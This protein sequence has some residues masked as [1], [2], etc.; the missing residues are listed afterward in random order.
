MLIEERDEAQNFHDYA[1]FPLETGDTAK[2]LAMTASRPRMGVR[3]LNPLAA[4]QA[5]QNLTEYQELRD[6]AR[7]S[8]CAV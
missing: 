2:L 6:A 5:Q 7:A 3:W 4:A 8:L 1:Q